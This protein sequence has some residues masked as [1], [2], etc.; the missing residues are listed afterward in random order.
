[1]PDFRQTVIDVVKFLTK[2]KRLET[3]FQNDGTSSEVKQIAQEFAK[4]NAEYD[5]YDITY[6]CEFLTGKQDSFH[7]ERVQ[8]MRELS[9]VVELRDAASVRELRAVT[10]RIHTKVKRELYEILGK[11]LDKKCKSTDR[12]KLL[13]TLLTLKEVMSASVVR[14]PVIT[15]MCMKL[16]RLELQTGQDAVDDLRAFLGTIDFT[17]IDY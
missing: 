3:L 15:A 6:I 12:E 16:G 14:D 17:G 4:A 10:T 5:L 9:P 2:S 11:L 7:Y 13:E 8:I 1:M